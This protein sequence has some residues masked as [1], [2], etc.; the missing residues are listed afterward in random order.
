ML[1]GCLDVSGIHLSQ[2][3]LFICRQLDATRPVGERSFHVE[4]W[5]MPS[6]FQWYRG[7]ARYQVTH[8]LV[9]RI[10]LTGQCFRSHSKIS[11]PLVRCSSTSSKTSHHSRARPSW[12]LYGGEKPDYSQPISM[13]FSYFIHGIV[14]WVHKTWSWFSQR[15]DKW[16]IIAIKKTSVTQE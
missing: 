10:N 8:R 14:F 15:I 4:N 11:C 13:F 9:V 6:I 5:N 2:Q 3:W 16:S 12:A 7:F 1:F